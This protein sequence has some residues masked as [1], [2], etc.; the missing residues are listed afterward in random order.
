[1]A[2]DYY[3]IASEVYRLDISYEDRYSVENIDFMARTI[4][5][6]FISDL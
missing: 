5:R 3:Q 6:L 1:M 4:N 2:P